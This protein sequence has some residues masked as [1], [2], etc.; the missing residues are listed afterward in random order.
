MPFEWG[1]V[2]V[3]RNKAL[4]KKTSW[5]ENI[6]QECLK[7]RE[8]REPRICCRLKCGKF[9]DGHW[10]E[11]PYRVAQMSQELSVH[12]FI[13]ELGLMREAARVGGALC[14]IGVIWQWKGERRT[15]IRK[16][17]VNYSFLGPVLMG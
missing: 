5:G 3:R 7:V 16:T 6:F 9:T 13:G 1:W 10:I 11:S 8:V 12:L 4:F 17:K 15:G 2:L 14:H